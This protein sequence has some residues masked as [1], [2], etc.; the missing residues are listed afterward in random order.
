MVILV[1]IVTNL[2][3][4][5]YAIY[6]QTAT[7]NSAISAGQAA[8]AAGFGQ[9]PVTVDSSGN[10]M[11]KAGAG[12]STI[13]LTPSDIAQTPSG[14]YNSQ[15]GSYQGVYGS[16]TA[17]TQAG[18][19]A[20]ANLATGNAAP[21]QAYQ[22]LTD[23]YKNGTGSF[24]ATDPIFTKATQT[25]NNN[26]LLST[27]AACTQTTS[28]NKTTTKMHVPS[29]VTCNIANP[30][31]N[32][33]TLVHGYNYPAPPPLVHN[34]NVAAGCSV[35]TSGA[36]A[37]DA[38]LT[39]SNCVGQ[40]I[41]L[42]LNNGGTFS[43]IDVHNGDGGYNQYYVNGQH[44][45]YT[46]GVG[47]VNCTFGVS[48]GTISLNYSGKDPVTAHVT[49]SVP[50]TQ[51]ITDSWSPQQ[52]LA[53]VSKPDA[54][55]TVTSTC[56]SMPSVDASGCALINGNYTCPSQMAA[57]PIAGINPLCQQVSAT[58]N[59]TQFDVGQG[60]TYTTGQG[61]S[62]TLASN[63]STPNGCLAYQNN[64][65]CVFQSQTC[66]DGALGGTTG[67]CY[68]QTQV[69]DC[70]TDTNVPTTT[71]T[72]SQNCTGPV[73]CMGT[74][75]SSVT[76]STTNNFAQATAALQVAQG[77][78]MDSNCATGTSGS[79]CSIFPGTAL[80]CKKA[81]GGI[82]DCCK[83]PVP[84]NFV[85]YIQAAFATHSA[86]TTAQSL[87]Y[88]GQSAPDLSY[89]SI[90]TQLSS[91]LGLDEGAD[92]SLLSQASEFISTAEDE[93]QSAATTWM[94]D[95]FGEEATTEIMTSMITDIIPG[96]NMIMML[97]TMY[98]IT[99]MIIQMV[100]QCESSEQNLAT[101]IADK[102]CHYLGTYCASSV[103]GACIETKDSYCCFSS[104]LSRIL[105]EQV[106]L[107]PQVG[108]SWGTAK[109]PNCQAITLAQ[110]G[111]VNWSQV[112]LSEWIAMLNIAN[113]GEAS[114][115][116]SA[117]GLT[118]SGSYLSQV[119]G[120]SRPN[121]VTR[122]INSSTTLTSTPKQ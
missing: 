112:D 23:V 50:N 104:P 98:Q 81:V 49:G 93:I 33:Y 32:T 40:T 119:T 117:D 86:Y 89:G 103:L 65:A 84:V 46:T 18:V 97:Y 79:S 17:M 41:T 45:G 16:N 73:Q 114:K 115:Q 83:T 60:D 47:N 78:Q 111:L 2:L 66:A 96:L 30:Q 55:C 100:W 110:L 27:F 92:P 34:L 87:G 19:N 1:C 4:T 12:G 118:G 44:C 5:S 68:V 76:Q 3:V 75:C 20:Q 35:S 29:Y 11:I 51:N 28:T 94:A 91:A 53:A 22:T 95:T 6:A 69:W 54:E 72:T 71:T 39:F 99:M 108:L 24:T 37:T 64:P 90:Q 88:L 8:G 105:Q 61:Q 58:V 77:L 56:T 59:C 31:I 52:Y 7:S 9:M 121:S 67:T 101:E 25:L 82:V 26:N 57:S 43:E 48:G 38:Y 21:N 63:G 74:S 42:T 80:T 13:T 122:A 15:V 36:T 62:T 106:R 14:T 120:T 107:Q 102:Q 85:T 113:V 70:G 116:L 109:N 10:M